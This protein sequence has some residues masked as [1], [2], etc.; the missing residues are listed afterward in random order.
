[1]YSGAFVSRQFTGISHWRI[2]LSRPILIDLRNYDYKQYGLEFTFPRWHRDIQLRVWKY[3]G[4]SVDA[5]QQDLQR[6]EKK[7]DDISN[8][9]V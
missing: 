4:E 5:V 6:I 2:G 7:I 9:S 3:I 1:M 8:F